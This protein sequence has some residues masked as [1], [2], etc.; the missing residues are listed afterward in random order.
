MILVFGADG[1][2]LGRRPFRGGTV[3]KQDVQYSS[4]EGV[5]FC[6]SAARVPMAIVY[7]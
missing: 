6:I 1:S 2:I 3:A 5:A 4:S 7:E